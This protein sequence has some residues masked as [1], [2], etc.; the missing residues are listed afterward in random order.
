VFSLFAADQVVAPKKLEPANFVRSDIKPPEPMAVYGLGDPRALSI[1]WPRCLK[2]SRYMA[3]AS[4]NN[5]TQKS[6]ARDFTSIRDFEWIPP[7]QRKALT[8][9][10][11]IDRFTASWPRTRSAFSTS[12][13]N[14]T[15]RV[16]PKRL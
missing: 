8:R 6:R 2:T 16:V 14:L 11:D 9:P 4:A 3:L 1:W 13:M 15:C 12:S 7:G 10:D 5:D